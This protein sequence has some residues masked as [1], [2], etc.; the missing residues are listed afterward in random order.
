LV[1]L[2][3]ESKSGASPEPCAEP[4]VVSAN[5]LLQH[6]SDTQ[7]SLSPDNFCQNGEALQW[8]IV[9]L[10]NHQVI[11]FRFRCSKLE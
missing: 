8:N 4:K 7:A 1:L 6:L 2:E 11:L 9:V 3:E 5:Y 10:E